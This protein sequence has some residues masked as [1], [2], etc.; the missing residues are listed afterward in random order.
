MPD[1]SLLSILIIDPYSGRI[2]PHRM[3]PIS[4]DKRHYEIS[5]TPA[6]ARQHTV[7]I[8][9]NGQTLSNNHIDVCDVNNIHVTSIDDGLVGVPSVFSVDTHGAGEGNLEVTISNGQ[10]TLPAELKSIQTRKFDIAFVPEMSG[11]HSI[12]ITFNGIPIKGS[13]FLINIVDPSANQSNNMDEN[14]QEVEY[15]EQ[16]EE[17]DNDHDDE[18][19]DYEFLIG[20]QLEGTKVGEVAWFIC[21]TL[22]TDMYEDFDLYIKGMLLPFKMDLFFFE[23]LLFL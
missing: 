9:Y 7:S 6:I 23:N 19:S 17:K 22:L 16:Q 13:P 12:A 3:I 5:F 10:K 21:E 20:G 14:K 11:T 1:P 2:I 15:E 8:S 18:D 4:K